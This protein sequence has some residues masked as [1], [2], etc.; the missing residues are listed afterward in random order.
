MNRAEVETFKRRTRELLD[1]YEYALQEIEKDEARRLGVAPEQTA[2]TGREIALEAQTRLYILDPLL[3]EMGWEVQAAAAIVVED[4]V[5]PPQ[6]DVDAHRRRLDYHGRDNNGARS[7]LAIEVKRPRVRLP[8]TGKKRV[9]DRMADALR[10][11]NAGGAAAEGVAAEWRKILASTIDYVKRIVAAYGAAPVRFVLTNGEWFLVFSDVNATILPSDPEAGKMVLFSDLSDVV[12]RAGEFCA[13]LGYQ[14]LSGHIPPQHPGALPDF[15]PDGEVATCSRFVDVSYTRHGA[16]QPLISASVGVWIRARR[17][18]WI[19][20]QKNYD[21][22]FLVLSDDR[23]ELATRRQQLHA[24]AESLLADL[25]AHRELRFASRDEFEG[26]P[27]A[28]EPHD[29]IPAAGVERDSILMRELGP[30]RYRITTTEQLLFFTD[31]G[32]YD[33]CP[34]HNWGA[35]REEGNAVG[36]SAITAPSSDPR[37]FFPSGSPYHC[38]HAGIR[39]RRNRV[40]LLLAFEEHLCC[41]RCVF[42]SRCWPETAGMPCRLN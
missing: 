31:E 27:S 37:C 2:G 30:D 24:R 42:L 36:Q 26:A 28:G 35:C 8:R 10:R 3:Q 21:N 4:N 17:G 13:L 18:A 33:M 25:G 5:E 14:D 6:E 23:D 34:Y 15:V 29:A 1:R 12:A 19:L 38:A 11:I 7:L 32:T 20:F 41:R 22:Q 40:C 16:R 9:E 39:A